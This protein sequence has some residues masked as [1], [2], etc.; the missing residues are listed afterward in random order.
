MTSV[1]N[2]SYQVNIGFTIILTL[3]SLIIADFSFYYTNILGSLSN[4]L[5][6]VRTY[7]K[8]FTNHKF[9]VSDKYCEKLKEIKVNASMQLGIMCGLIK[10]DGSASFVS[11]K[12]STSRE[13][14]IYVRYEYL[15]QVKEINN[16]ILTED[17]IGVVNNAMANG[18]THFV[19]KIHYGVGATLTLKK[20]ISEEKDKINAEAQLNICGTA[21]LK[22]LEKGD[23]N[24]E[25][26][27]VASN[28]VKTMDIECQFQCDCTIGNLIPPT[29]FE[30]ALEFAGK[31]SQKLTQDDNDNESPEVPCIVWL[32]PLSSLPQI[33]AKP[34]VLHEIDDILVWQYT[35]LFEQYDELENEVND[36]LNGDLLKYKLT[37]VSKKLEEFKML[38]TS[39]RKK[40]ETEIQNL[41]VA[42]VSG[43]K[44]D[45]SLKQLLEL[46]TSADK[47]NFAYHP[48]ALRQWLEEKCEEVGMVKRITDKILNYC[49]SRS[50]VIVFP[51]KR[52][53]QEE[54]SKRLVE[55]TFVFNFT[56][57]ARPE[58]FLKRMETHRQGRH[59]GTFG[60]SALPQ[61]IF[62]RFLFF[63]FYILHFVE[64]WCG[65]GG[66]WGVPFTP[67]A[68]PGR[69]GPAHRSASLSAIVADYV[70]WSLQPP[71]ELHVCWHKAPLLV[72]QIEEK[73]AF[74]ADFVN[75]SLHWSSVT[76]AITASIE[77]NDEYA[78]GGISLDI[79]N[80]SNLA[81]RFGIDSIGVF[82]YETSNKLWHV[83]EKL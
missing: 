64:G 19:S 82:P 46:F 71:E 59:E 16:L 15:N 55:R 4:S 58:P 14:V 68:N 30:G 31:L 12:K 10:A 57:L 47:E 60:E 34:I 81:K 50:Q 79:Y 32:Q 35:Q 43:R 5:N 38:L 37:P 48:K 1:L 65:V 28:N 45:S 29:T 27:Y 76:I 18:A 40:L 61:G 17:Q 63:I 2:K 78:F 75:Y 26:R 51:D 52:K 62:S 22:C 23:I 54:M 80:I 66:A 13:R 6:S 56:S 44:D 72:K 42:I 73:A 67:G 69:D 41:T 9:K 36:M 8:P 7:K 24:S 25:G 77:E 83:S 33:K 74:Y 53:F 3:L 70:A 49:K 21:V 39:F 11:S 20:S